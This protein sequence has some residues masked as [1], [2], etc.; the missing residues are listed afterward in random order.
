MERYPYR[1][2]LGRVMW[3]QLATRPD[4]CFPVSLLARFQSNPGLE[5]WKALLHVLGYVKGTMDVGIAFSRD[6]PLTPIGFVDADYGGCRDTAR[7]TSGYVFTMAGG[8]I[9]WSS[10]RQATVALSTVEAEYVSLTRAA[11]Q[12]MWILSWMDEVELPQ[13]RPGILYG[14]NQGAVA[15]T[16][17]TRSHQKVKHIRIREHFIREL[18]NGG[19]LR[20]DFIRGN[21]NPADMFTKPLPRDT[22]HGYL[23]MLSI[24]PVD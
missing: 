12:M 13:P 5:H 18:V 1:R 15:L 10:K 19:E 7:S 17:N 3:G 22:H 8:P 11:Q 4:L 6:Q 2:L 23:D 20:V 14:D 24:V 21:V 16:T 9:C